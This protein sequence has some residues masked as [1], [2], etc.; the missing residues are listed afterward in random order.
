MAEPLDLEPDC[1]S[2][3]GLCCVATEFKQ[4]EQYAF[5]KPGGETCRHLSADFRCGIHKD[6]EASRMKGCAAYTCFGAGQSVTQRLFPGADWRE[7]PQMAREIFDTFYKLKELHELI[8][9]LRLTLSACPEGP[10]RD[11]VAARIEEVEGHAHMDASATR[12]LDID[13][14]RRGSQS[15]VD[16][17]HWNIT[18]GQKDG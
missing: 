9:V 1:D 4:S 10:E 16:A 12:A 8:W 7:D 13:D 17:V 15:A 14:L 3:T 2:C 5:S 18:I 6:L 11:R